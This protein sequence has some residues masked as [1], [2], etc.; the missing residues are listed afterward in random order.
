[1]ALTKLEAGQC[2]ASWAVVKNRDFILMQGLKSR[3]TFS[4][5]N[6]VK[7]RWLWLLDGDEI[8]REKSGHSGSDGWSLLLS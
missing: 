5:L 3:M 6:V 4:H 2:G 1:M 8:T 7:E